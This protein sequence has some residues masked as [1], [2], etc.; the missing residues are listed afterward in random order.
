MKKEKKPPI[1]WIERFLFSG[2]RLVAELEEVNYGGLPTGT[3]FWKVKIHDRHVPWDEMGIW[4]TRDAAVK[5]AERNY[6]EAS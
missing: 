4:S 2:G 3:H 1:H 5:E 6:T